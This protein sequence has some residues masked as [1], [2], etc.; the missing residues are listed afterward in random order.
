MSLRIYRL[1]TSMLLLTGITGVMS[2]STE[3]LQSKAARRIAE[4]RRRQ[5][6][7][8]APAMAQFYGKAPAPAAIPA[9]AVSKAMVTRAGIEP[10]MHGKKP[11]AA[12]TVSIAGKPPVSAKIAGS[13]KSKEVVPI[14]PV[15][16]QGVRFATELATIRPI[17]PR[18]TL[19]QEEEQEDY[20][21]EAGDEFTPF[22]D[23]C[24]IALTDDIEHSRLSSAPV[25][26][27]LVDNQLKTIISGEKNVAPWK[28]Y[29]AQLINEIDENEYVA[30][31]NRVIDEKSAILEKFLYGEVSPE[32]Y[33]GAEF[34][35]FAL[36]FLSDYVSL[37]S[38]VMQTFARE[39]AGAMAGSRELSPE[40]IFNILNEV[41][42]SP[43]FVGAFIKDLRDIIASNRQKTMVHQE[44]FLPQETGKLEAAAV[45]EEEEGPSEA[46]LEAQ[47]NMLK[48]VDAKLNAILTHLDSMAGDGRAQEL[49]ARYVVFRNRYEHFHKD[50]YVDRTA[51]DGFAIR[52]L[53]GILDKLL[54][55]VQAARSAAR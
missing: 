12:T 24:V 28:K 19:S 45:T 34:Q 33:V 26:L 29:F 14:S 9:P 47:K 43:R 25:L 54:E 27:E 39:L 18:S 32:D 2:A 21:Q 30:M 8:V 36:E 3:S 11:A 44:T 49:R 55:D 16:Q 46:S 6:E 52:M 31:L 51:I 23:S 4:N 1:V 7:I 38:S 13:G 42:I 40:Y 5:R 10:K 22:Q 50:T 48:I 53:I 41:L 17:S 15:Q 35:E 20:A 37:I